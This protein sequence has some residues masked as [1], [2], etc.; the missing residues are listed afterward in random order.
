MDDRVVSPRCVSTSDLV[1]FGPERVVGGSSRER[2][3]DA[4]LLRRVRTRAAPRPARVCRRACAW[5]AIQA[6]VVAIG[7]VLAGCG[8]EEEPTIQRTLGPLMAD[9]FA[10]EEPYGTP[11][12]PPPGGW[13]NLEGYALELQAHAPQKALLANMPTPVIYFAQEIVPDEHCTNRGLGISPISML[14]VTNYELVRMGT[15]DFR[16]EPFS[17][18]YRYRGED[19]TSARI[20]A[21]SG[22]LTLEGWDPTESALCGQ[23]DVGFP[24]GGHLTG[25]FQASASSCPL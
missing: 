9:M 18:L 12:K 15:N 19:G 17:L 1:P 8:Q 11:C 16:F 6:V 10:E 7:S 21:D 3:R 25:P 23:L 22:T 14:L 13:A 24:D 4:G 5:A 2:S 20:Q